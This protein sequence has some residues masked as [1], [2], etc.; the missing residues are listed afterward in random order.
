MRTFYV[1]PESDRGYGKGD[2]T[3]KITF[4]FSSSDGFSISRK[5][6]EEQHHIGFDLFPPLISHDDRFNVESSIR[7]KCNKVRAPIRRPDLILRAD[8]FTDDL[9]FDPHRFPGQPF[10]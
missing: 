7:M 4:T 8:S 10:R 5:T 9:L 3:D 1:R 6:G 2:G